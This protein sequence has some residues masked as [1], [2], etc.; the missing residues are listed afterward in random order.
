MRIIQL[1]VKNSDTVTAPEAIED[2]RHVPNSDHM[3]EE[4]YGF[5]IRK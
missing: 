1:P 3:I 2:G 4:T 5:L